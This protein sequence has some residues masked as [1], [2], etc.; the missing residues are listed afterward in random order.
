MTL[1]RQDWSNQE[2]E[3]TVADYFDMLDKELRHVE[4][5]K[6]AHRR[7]LATLL[8]KR[9]DAAIERKHQNISLFS[10][11]DC[12]SPT[13]LATNRLGTTSNFSTT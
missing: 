5:N 13:Y 12:I 4:Y 1:E 9:S 6:T 11:P 3:A 8:N 10:I 2:V 7:F